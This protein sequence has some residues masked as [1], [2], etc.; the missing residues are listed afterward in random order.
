MGDAC[1]LPLCYMAAFFF[2]RKS[3]SDTAKK[4]PNAGGEVTEREVRHIMYDG[5][6][7]LCE[8]AIHAWV[9]G[10]YSPP[11]G[12]PVSESQKAMER[13]NIARWREIEAQIKKNGREWLGIE[14]VK[15]KAKS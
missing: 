11:P 14:P 2:E 13:D 9:S 6:L 4:F 12:M 10:K 5:G 8:Y 7:K 1:A 3:M 15:R